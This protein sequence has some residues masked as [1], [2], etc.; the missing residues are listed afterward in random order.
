MAINVTLTIADLN[1]LTG[2]YANE[3]NRSQYLTNPIFFN[4]ISPLQSA[5]SVSLTRYC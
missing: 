5:K 1:G 4:Q 2:I 3:R